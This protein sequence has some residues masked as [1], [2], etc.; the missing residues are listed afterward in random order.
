M[1]IYLYIATAI[2]LFIV[3]QTDGEWNIVKHTLKD[4]SLTSIAVT[5]GVILA[6]TRDGIWRS[7][8]NGRTWTESNRNLAIRYVR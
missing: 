6:G 7:T 2:G 1:G 8:D 3:A 4:H 5:E